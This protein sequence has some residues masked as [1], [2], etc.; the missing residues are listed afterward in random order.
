MTSLSQTS[1]QPVSAWLPLLREALGCEG[2]FRW[3]LRG[4]SM[5]PTLPTECEIE[6][7]PLPLDVRLGDLIVFVDGDTLVAHRLVRRASGNR[8]VTQGDG[9]LGPD[10]PLDPAQVLARVTIAYTGG[11]RCWPSA[12]SYLAAPLWV[13]RHHLLRP[14]R[15]AWRAWRRLTPK[16]RLPHL[17]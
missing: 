2:H 13:A 4:T 1:G 7:V 16:N 6:M 15:L 5:A 14:L 17:S 11:R 12:F 10:R 9:R 3:P 8:W